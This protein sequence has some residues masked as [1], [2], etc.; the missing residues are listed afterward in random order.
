VKTTKTMTITK[1]SSLALAASVLACELPLDQL[2]VGDETHGAD[3]DTGTD[4]SCEGEGGDGDG[5]APLECVVQ[6][7]NVAG[8]DEPIDFEFPECEVVCATGWGHGA[9]PLANEWTLDLE[10]DDANTSYTF[11]EATPTGELVVVLGQHNADARLVW[12]SPDGELLAQLTQPAINNDVWDVAITNEGNIFVLWNQAIMPVVTA[13][14]SSG[15]HLWTV[16]IGPPY[17]Y[18]SVLAALG[19]GVVVALNSTMVPDDGDLVHVDSNG[20]VM[21]LGSIPPTEEIAVSPSGNTVVIANTTTISR[22][23]FKL[24]P[25]GTSIQDVADVNYVAGLVAPDDERV[26]IA[27]SA[28]NW[29]EQGSQ[30]AFVE[31]IGPMGLEWEGRYDRALDWCEFDSTTELMWDVERLADGS[32]LVVGIESARDIFQPWVGH[33]S[34]QGEVLATDRGF[35][36]GAAAAIAS[37]QDAAYVL[38][39]EYDEASQQ[40]IYLRKYL[41]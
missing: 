34:A 13:L 15:E 8:G 20:Q 28:H 5:G 11:L 35:W 39:F 25:M 22:M 2:E 32:L 7:T 9:A 1:W 33:V 23:D 36:S 21:G 38:L 24:F 14:S 17:S 3:E 16:E 10:H 27:G 31:Q 12:V 40:H 18:N 19:S 26:V 37:T 4:S 30:H 29:N 41:P 6:G